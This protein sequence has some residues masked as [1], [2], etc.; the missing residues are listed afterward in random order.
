MPKK[1]STKISVSILT[2]TY[3]RRKFIELAIKMFKAQDYPQELMEWIILDDGE[4]KVG[5]LFATMPDVR[6][7]A[8][9]DGVRLPIG[10]KRN[11]LNDLSRGELIVC[12]DDDDYFPPQR[13]RKSVHAL[14]AIPGRAVQVAG[15]STYFM[16]YADRDEVWCFGPKGGY[17]CTN[18]TMAYWSSY[19]GNNR[20]DETATKAEER[21]FLRDYTIP[22]IQMNSEDVIVCISHSQNTVDKRMMI[23]PGVNNSLFKKTSLKLRDIVKESEIREFYKSLVNDYAP[24]D[25]VGGGPG[26]DPP[27]PPGGG[28][29]APPGGGCGGPGGGPGGGPA[30]GGGCGAS[31]PPNIN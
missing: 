21:K 16:Y 17:H 12:I 22:V 13:V 18:G 15:C 31:A 8:L 24:G 25:G 3:N 28:P 23:A 5:D 19:F 26:G 4:D 6:Y 27:A 2:P 7:V 11:M 29:P 1:R 20:Y 14:T 9:P 10:A 30:S